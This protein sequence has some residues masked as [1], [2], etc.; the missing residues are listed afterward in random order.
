M[1][2][3]FNTEVA[4][5]A[6]LCHVQTEDHGS[7]QCLIETVVY[8]RGRVVH[9]KATNYQDL[10][11]SAG[12]TE[13]ALRLRV[14]E[15]HRIIIEK[16]RSGAI[17]IAA[18]DPSSDVGIQ[19]RLCN[20]GSWHAGGI[21]TLE[22]EVL[23]RADG[24]PVADAELEARFEGAMNPAQFTALSDAHGRAQI[25]F[26][27]PPGPGE[28]ELIIRARADSSFDEIRYLLRPKPKLSS[29]AKP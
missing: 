23:R 25:R 3:G 9:R 14:E 27:L 17:P 15:Q 20:S 5:A 26:S 29:P 2:F 7:G 12:F 16:L 19:V 28:V 22:V 24:K 11:A 4:V 6:G 21:A 13:D 1:I 10:V 8:L 18:A